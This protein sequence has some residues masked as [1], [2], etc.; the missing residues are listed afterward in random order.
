MTTSPTATDAPKDNRLQTAAVLLVAGF[1]VHN[2]DHARRGLDSVTES[3]VWAG[4]LL[5]VLATV[6]VTLILT[7]HAL[8]AAAATV[9]GFTIVFGVSASHLLPNWG[10]ISDSLPQGDVD[11][12][13]WLAVFSEILAGLWLGWVGLSILRE[14]DFQIGPTLAT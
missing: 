13:T 6:V 11:V 3:L 5:M 12:F 14:N 9:M 10:P 1:I 7:R 8:S 2:A 4:T